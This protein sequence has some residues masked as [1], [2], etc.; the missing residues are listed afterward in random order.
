MNFLRMETILSPLDIVFMLEGS[1]CMLKCRVFLERQS[2]AGKCFS[3][4]VACEESL[5]ALKKKLPMPG[6]N[7]RY[8]DKYQVLGWD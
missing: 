5:E 6:P 8:S 7:P 3:T 4:V 1:N 2:S